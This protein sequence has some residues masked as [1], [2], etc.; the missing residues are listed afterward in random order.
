MDYQV[1]YIVVAG[2]PFAATVMDWLS[3]AISERHHSHHDT[4]EAPSSLFHALVVVMVCMGLLGVVAGIF[5]EASE[6]S[7]SFPSVMM[8]FTA[9]EI[10][11]FAIWFAMKR[12]RVV[13]YEDHMVVTPFIGRPA[14]ISY[15][16][17]TALKWSRLH[18]GFSD[19]SIHVY[20]DGKRTATLWDGIDIDQ[21]LTTIDRF[22]LLEVRGT[23]AW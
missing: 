18:F 3:S 16:D 23:Y 2:I 6:S 8:F 4:Y 9:F 12:Y 20:V 11:L 19:A 22:D 5:I 14:S 13:T 21:V 17:I 15:A 1:L 10:V 7:W